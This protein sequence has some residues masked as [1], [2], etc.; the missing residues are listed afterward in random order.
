M[1]LAISGISSLIRTPGMSVPISVNGPPVGA[2]GLGSHVSNWLAPPASQRRMTRLLVFLSALF[3]PVSAKVFTAALV[4]S[5]PAPIAPTPPRNARRLRSCSAEPQKLLLVFIKLKLSVKSHFRAGHQRP[6]HLLP[7]AF[8]AVLAGIE[9][10]AQELDFVGGGFTRK[11]I[12]V[13]RL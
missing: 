10:V 13:G 2:P 12:Q 9:I 7:G 6:H 5:H 11:G 4:P 3:R 1:R 8:L